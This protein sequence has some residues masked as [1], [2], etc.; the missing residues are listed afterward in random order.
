META[1]IINDG[2][3]TKKSII[4]CVQT[5]PCSSGPAEVGLYC[6]HVELFV[7]STLRPV[8]WTYLKINLSVLTSPHFSQD[9]KRRERGGGK[10]EEKWKLIGKEGGCK[11][12]EGREVGIE[13]EGWERKDESRRVRREGGKGMKAKTRRERGKRVTKRGEKEGGREQG[14]KQ[15]GSK[16]G[17]RDEWKHSQ[18]RR[19]G[20][21]GQ[22][23]EGKK[24]GKR[25]HDTSTLATSGGKL[26]SSQVSSN[27][28]HR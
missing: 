13:G 24:E 11:R 22:R 17:E 25:Q 12:D 7:A 1:N 21:D 10:M 5:A 19:G 9:C 16:Q 23:N 26:S 3:Q 15:K 6:S 28:H 27:H 2:K 20:K 8:T 18:R 14:R 4:T